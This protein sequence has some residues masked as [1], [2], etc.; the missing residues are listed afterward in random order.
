[1]LA[2]IGRTWSLYRPADMIDFN[3]GE[4]RAKWIT[5]LGIIT[6]YPELLAAIGGAVVLWRQRRRRA[7]WVLIVPAITVTIGVALTYGQTRFRASA[8]PS[9][10]LL[11]AIGLVAAFRAW[12]GRGAPATVPVADEEPA[13]AATP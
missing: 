13:P 3:A 7:L 12:T 2:R 10:A 5:R 8:E 6:Y 1:M 11:A 9:L 4:D